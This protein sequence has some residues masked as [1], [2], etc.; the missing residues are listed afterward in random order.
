MMFSKAKGGVLHLDHKNP[1]STAG[2]GQ[3]GW[4]TAQWK[5]SWGCWLAATE[6]EPAR[7]QVAKKDKSILACIS[8]GCA[9][10]TRTAIA[11]LHWALVRLSLESYI[12]FWLPPNKKDIEGLKQ[13]QRTATKLVRGSENKS[14]EDQP[15]EAV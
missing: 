5:R 1:R 15:R 12:Q 9:S 10:R 4:D 3:N 14:C 13:V 11:L 6:H 8:N 2:L 7:A